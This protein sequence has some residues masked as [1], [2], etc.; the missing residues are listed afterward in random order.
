MLFRSGKV[1]A[2]IF[3]A[4]MCAQPFGNALYGVLFEICQ[5]MEWVVVLFACVVSMLIAVGVWRI[6]E[7]VAEQNPER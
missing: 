5:G 4:A 6:F 2:L 1:M 3:T 7:G